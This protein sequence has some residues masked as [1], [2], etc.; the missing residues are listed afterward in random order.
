MINIDLSHP[1]LQSNYA[2]KIKVFQKGNQDFV[3]KNFSP[4]NIVK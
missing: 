1:L 3:F 2:S 4:E